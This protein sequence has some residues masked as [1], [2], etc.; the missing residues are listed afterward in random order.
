MEAEDVE[1]ALVLLHSS[2]MATDALVDVLLMT[3]P[4]PSEALEVLRQHFSSL[5][6]STALELARLGD[7]EH[8][9]ALNQAWER[10]MHRAERYL[11]RP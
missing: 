10:A 1:R 6:A 11:R 9:D 5:R 8:S 2:T 7:A 4:A 3:H